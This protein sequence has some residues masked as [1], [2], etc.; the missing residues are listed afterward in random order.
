MQLMSLGQV[1]LWP[2][3]GGSGCMDQK[4][5]RKESLNKPWLYRAA[6]HAVTCMTASFHSYGVVVCC[7]ASLWE[8]C[9][10]QLDSEA[11]RHADLSLKERFSRIRELF[12]LSRQCQYW[13]YHKHCSVTEYE[14]IPTLFYFL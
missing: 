2:T 13:E 14:G 3:A 6:S 9:F 10:S 5:C 8:R 4:P 7:P 11:M 1:A 12:L